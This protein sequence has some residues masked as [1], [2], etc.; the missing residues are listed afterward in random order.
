MLEPILK[1]ADPYY[2]QVRSTI[3]VEVTREVLNRQFSYLN[4][5]QYGLSMAVFAH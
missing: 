1:K 2:A 3:N 5:F 4:D